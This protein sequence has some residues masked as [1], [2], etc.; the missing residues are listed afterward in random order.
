MNGLQLSLV[1]DNPYQMVNAVDLIPKKCVCRRSAGLFFGNFG[2]QALDFR[3]QG[4]N[5]LFQFGY[6]DR[7]K[8]LADNHVGWLFWGII[9]VHGG[10]HPLV[11]RHFG[12]AR[13]C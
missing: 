4:L 8:I 1:N 3:V 13:P 12:I 6:R 10:Y 2:A 9:E 11:L 5:A 7:I